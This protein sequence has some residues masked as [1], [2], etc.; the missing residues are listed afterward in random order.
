MTLAG[1]TMSLPCQLKPMLVDAPRRNPTLA[2]LLAAGGR[3]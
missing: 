2:R 1:R 3:S